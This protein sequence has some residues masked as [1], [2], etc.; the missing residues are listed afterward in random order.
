MKLNG[1]FEDDD[2][3]NLAY[4]YD[5]IQE[6]LQK[7]IAKTH[8]N[9]VDPR[10]RHMLY[11]EINDIIEE[12]D[13]TE[14]K[15]Y[16]QLISS[17]FEDK[18]VVVIADDLEKK[19]R[20][21]RIAALKLFVFCIQNRIPYNNNN[22]N[23]SDINHDNANDFFEPYILN[24]KLFLKRL[25]AN[26]TYNFYIIKKGMYYKQIVSEWKESGPYTT[27]SAYIRNVCCTNDSLPP[28]EILK[29]LNKTNED[30]YIWSIP[31]NFNNAAQGNT[32]IKDPSKAIIGVIVSNQ[33]ENNNN[34]MLEPPQM[35]NI[36][37]INSNNKSSRSILKTR[38]ISERNEKV[39]AMI[40]EALHNTKYEVLQK[41]KKL[42][43]KKK[44][45]QKRK[46]MLLLEKETKRV[47][48]EKRML[49]H[50]TKC[51]NE[52]TTMPAGSYYDNSTYNNNNNGYFEGN[53]SKYDEYT[54]NTNT[55]I[56]A[57]RFQ[58]NKLFFKNKVDTNRK[59]MEKS[60]EE[61]D[62]HILWTSRRNSVLA[63]KRRKAGHKS[64]KLEAKKRHNVLKQKIND[65]RV[66]R[67]MK[68]YDEYTNQLHNESKTSSPDTQYIK[69]AGL[70]ADKR[71]YNYTKKS[72][73]GQIRKTQMQI[74]PRALR[75]AYDLALRKLEVNTSNKNENLILVPHVIDDRRKR[76][77]H[78]I[79]FAQEQRIKIRQ[80]QQKTEAQDRE[81]LKELQFE[82]LEAIKLY[83]DIINSSAKK[84]NHVP[85]EVIELENDLKPRPPP[86]DLKDT[87][88]GR[89][90]EKRM[91][92][93]V[94]KIVQTHLVHAA[95]KERKANERRRPGASGGGI[96]KI[97]GDDD[98]LSVMSQTTIN[99]VIDL[100]YCKSRTLLEK[101]A[102]DEGIMSI[103]NDDLDIKNNTS[104]DSVR[105]NIPSVF[106]PHVPITEHKNSHR[107]AFQHLQRE[108]IYQGRSPLT[109]FR[110][111]IS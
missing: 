89:W 12:L 6:K 95:E 86:W 102:Q 46:A 57:M 16:L 10:R 3:N 17:L 70:T 83:N 67:A 25:N 80:E 100:Q 30:G 107:K 61:R 94:S 56:T 101:A 48:I 2:G 91:S 60:K 58:R 23:I 13:A 52:I 53:A 64:F 35:H 68:I 81:D 93:R 11:I 111:S 15:Q 63:R 28:L 33:D 59:N 47:E 44:M 66:R 97:G 42:D 103:G 43:R 92:K 73:Q 50:E 29:T 18:H 69:N 110:N 98:G 72:K 38:Y 22:N 109:K 32:V 90:P 36:A 37:N 76:G 85:I 9:V 40:E 82:K 1:L 84:D 24:L 20:G 99:K 55:S 65:A 5:L 41:K 79:N 71:R 96:F 106:T 19:D 88:Y 108:T 34:K 31:N 62:K 27:L 14:D 45:V 78:K 54:N 51:K 77:K 87:S 104:D 7:L 74:S 8:G 4:A 39:Q 49:K 105:G 21:L 75:E 26:R